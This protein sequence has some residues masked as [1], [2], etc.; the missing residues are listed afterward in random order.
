[1]GRV[2]RK[3]FIAFETKEQFSSVSV[4]A[5]CYHYLSLLNIYFK[6]SEAGCSKL[7]TSLVNVTLNFLT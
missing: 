5:A 7:T 3:P 4:Q 6:T 2:V 1:M